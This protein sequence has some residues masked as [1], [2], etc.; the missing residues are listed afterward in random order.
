MDLSTLLEA[1]LLSALAVPLLGG[2]A[3]VG[4]VHQRV[5]RNDADI[6]AF[7]EGLTAHIAADAIAHQ[8]IASME[9]QLS[10]ALGILQ[11][12]DARE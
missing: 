5:N 6:K 8:R 10:I 11:K 4:R 3:W 9:G 2:A 7:T 12:L 1:P